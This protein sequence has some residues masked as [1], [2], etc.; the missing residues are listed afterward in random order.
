M[1]SNLRPFKLPENLKFG[2]ATASLQIEGGDRNN[3]WFDW[4]EAGKVDHNDHCISACD[5]WNRYLED[6]QLMAEMGLQTYRLSI[7]WSRIF[8]RRKEVDFSAVDH[9]RKILEELLNRGIE[10]VVTLHHFSNPRWLEKNGGW[11]CPSILDDFLFYVRTC[12]EGFGNFVDRW[13]TINEPN[14]YLFGGYIEGHWPPGNKSVLKYLKG[15]RNM[16]LAHNAAYHEIHTLQQMAKVGVA[17]HLRV[18]ERADQAS[19]TRLSARVQEFLFQ[20]IFLEG[21]T[22]S[23]LPFPLDIGDQPH[24]K[25]TCDFIGINYYSRD[26]IQGLQRFTLED[27]PRNDLDWEIYPHGLYRVCKMVHDRYGLPISITENGIADAADTR[28]SRFIHD[29]LMEIHKA[30]HDGVNIQDY[31]HWSLM[32]NFEWAEGYAPRFGLI[33]IDYSSQERIWR[34]SGRFYQDICQN[35]AV[36]HE[37][38]NTYLEETGE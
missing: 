15:A 14:V 22:R 17:H 3:S 32:D 21:M 34:N 25:R 33:E 37:A 19:L 26:M 24:P 20:D 7:E 5:H 35:R 4:C 16:I 11:L 1:P 27:S 8:P 28:R 18:F 38:I 10:P 31:F 2:A 29:H 12:V 30:C 23:Y 36:T 13:I 6:I 9:Y